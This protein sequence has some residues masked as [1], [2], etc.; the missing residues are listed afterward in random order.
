MNLENERLKIRLLALTDLEDSF[1]HRADPEVCRYVGQPIT[2]QETQQ[3]IEQAMK[4]WQGKE[5]HK[6]FL[7][8]ELKSENKLIG[9]L[10]FKYSNRESGLGEFGCRVN[11]NYQGRG[12]A[13]EA[14]R[15]LL[16]Y[17]FQELNVHKIMAFCVAENSASWRLMQKLNMTREGHL[18]SHFKIEN[19]WMDAYLY[20]LNRNQVL[21]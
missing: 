7:A 4:P 13:F 5:H 6:L 21:N 8:I 15:C 12:Y 1:E 20:A 11:K 19:E 10:M 2:K 16:D 17:L 18:K 14:S 3:K 9:E